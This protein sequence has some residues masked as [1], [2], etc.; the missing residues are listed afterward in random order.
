MHLDTI[1][2]YR[3]ANLTPYSDSDDNVAPQANRAV[4]AQRTQI[5]PIRQGLIPCSYPLLRKFGYVFA[6]YKKSGTGI[7]L[8]GYMVVSKDAEKDKAR[9]IRILNDYPDFINVYYKRVDEKMVYFY[10]YQVEPSGKKIL[11]DKSTTPQRIM[12]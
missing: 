4:E 6:S 7:R 8:N 1:Y 2:T 3:K 10:T 12:L 5:N 11:I 9:E